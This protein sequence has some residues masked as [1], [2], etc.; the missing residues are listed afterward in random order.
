MGVFQ[1]ESFFDAPGLA[2][3]ARMP[4]PLIHFALPGQ[5]PTIVLAPLTCYD[6][7]NPTTTKP[8]T[9]LSPYLSIPSLTKT[10]RPSYVAIPLS[11][12]IVPLHMLQAPPPHSTVW[13]QPLDPTFWNVVERAVEHSVHGAAALAWLFSEI[14]RATP[15]KVRSARFFF[16]RSCLISLLQSLAPVRDDRWPPSCDSLDLG[17]LPPIPTEDDLLC[18][19]MTELGSIS[20]S[21]LYM[22]EA[23]LA[24]AKLAAPK[25]V[26]PIRFIHS[27]QTVDVYC[28]P[29]YPPR[30]NR[31]RHQVLPIQP[32]IRSQRATSLAKIYPCSFKY[33]TASCTTTLA[34]HH[35]GRSIRLLPLSLVRYHQLEGGETFTC[36]PFRD[37][38]GYHSC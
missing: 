23:E 9:I 34:L 10:L 11:Y 30:A 18:M 17:F 22:G 19:D 4:P 27:H 32:W 7:M 5:A 1:D 6:F 8:F 37:P 3:A 24:A 21:D 13:P 38:F 28:N 29:S 36:D 31:L 16:G 12:A 33:P 25:L 26:Y 35:R 15:Q 20:S 14:V 2:L